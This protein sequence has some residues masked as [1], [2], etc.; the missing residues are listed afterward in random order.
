MEKKNCKF[1]SEDVIAIEELAEQL[2]DELDINE[3]VEQAPAAE[4]TVPIVEGEDD[5]NIDDLIA[6]AESMI[7][8]AELPD[9]KDVISEE[10]EAD[11]ILAEAD[12]LEKQL[13][14]CEAGEKCPECGS[15]MV[16]SGKKKSCSNKDC[17]HAL[18]N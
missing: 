17:R 13:D 1:A 8:E 2:A 10:D 15:Y 12:E 3:D 7:A 18:K 16:A 11:Q 6:E 4:D 5:G 9:E 14:A